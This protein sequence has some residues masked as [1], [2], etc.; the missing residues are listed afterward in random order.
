METVFKGFKKGM[1][2]FG[3]NITI[4]INSILLSIVYIIGIGLTSIIAKIFKKSFLD[5]KISKEKKSYWS[6][7]N[8]KKKSLDKYYRQ[9]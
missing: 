3:H 6:E 2:D 8:L 9:F 4:I 1:Q 7:L 5:T